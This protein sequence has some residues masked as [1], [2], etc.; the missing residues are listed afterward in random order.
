MYVKR[1]AKKVFKRGKKFVKRRY[2][3]RKGKLRTRRIARDV[4]Y[5]KSVINSEKKHL[6]TDVEDVYVGQVNGN[7]NGYYLADVSPAPTQGTGFQNRIGNSIKLHATHWEMMIARQSGPSIINP[8]KMNIK[9]IE[10]VGEPYTTPS[11]A[12]EGKFLYHNPFIDT[13]NIFDYH[14]GRVPEYF[15]NYRVLKNKNIFMPGNSIGGQLSNKTIKFGLK[16]KNL[17]IKWKGDSVNQSVGQLLLLI[18][19]DSGNRSTTTTSTLDNIYQAGTSTGLLIQ[20]YRTDYFY[21]N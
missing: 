15:K 3:G 21:D 18:T 14:S 9:I 10:V 4:A 7:A 1:I 16:Y 12:I 17:H 13:T 2:V 11:N 5:L 8:I 6:R 19:C 20:H